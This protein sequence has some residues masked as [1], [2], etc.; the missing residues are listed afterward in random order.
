MTLALPQE[1][2]CIGF[3]QIEEGGESIL[4]RRNSICK[5]LELGLSV[6]SLKVHSSFYERKRARRCICCRLWVRGI[7]RQAEELACCFVGCSGQFVVTQIFIFPVFSFLSENPSFPPV[8][9]LFS[10]KKVL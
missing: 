7:G 10:L 6:A 8:S 3:M 4:G 9:F 5:G 2:V 1:H